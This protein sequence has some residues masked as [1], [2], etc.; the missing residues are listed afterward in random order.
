MQLA[1]RQHEVLTYNSSGSH[2]KS[3]YYKTHQ[4]D[5]AFDTQKYL[6]QI[7]LITLTNHVKRDSN[8]TILEFKEVED[9]NLLRLQATINDK[10]LPA[11]LQIQPPIN[12][13]TVL[14]W[15]Q[16]SI[17]KNNLEN[18]LLLEPEIPNS[19]LG[20]FLQKKIKTVWRRY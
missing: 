2:H 1:H 20:N 11:F 5:E 13:Y 14:G 17:A 3:T 16:V 18:S 6:L 8:R 7:N 19:S 9:N 15:F 10:F 4:K 12:A